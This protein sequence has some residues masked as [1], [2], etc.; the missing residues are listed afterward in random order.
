[1]QTAFVNGTI[2][3]GK[4]KV[5]GKALIIENDQIKEITN[6]ELI[7]ENIKKID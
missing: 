2:F 7:A 1:M 4:E 5:T 6:N 3:T